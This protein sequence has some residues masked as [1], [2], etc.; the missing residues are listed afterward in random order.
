[1]SISEP[2][3]HSDDPT[4]PRAVIYAFTLAVVVQLIL[5]WRGWLYWDQ[6]LLYNLGTDFATGG[7]LQPFGK[8]TSGDG[9]VPGSLLQL[10]V[11]VPLSLWMNTRASSLA[12]VL[13]QLAVLPLVY[14]ATRSLFQRKDVATWTAVLFALSPWRLYHG[15]FI[16]E[17]NY[18]LILGPIHYW[19]CVRLY[20]RADVRPWWPS[21]IL[22]WT[23]VAAP[24]LHLSGVIL[25]LA[26]AILFAAR[27]FRPHWPAL[28]AGLALGTATLI[29]TLRAIAGG[30]YPF[31]QSSDPLNLI[32]I[33]PL[34]DAYHYWVR[35]ASSDLGRRLRQATDSEFLEIGVG[36][37][38]IFTILL[39]LWA[40]WSVWRRNRL[41]HDRQDDRRACYYCWSLLFGLLIAN[42]VSDLAPQGWYALV[43]AHGSIVLFAL[44]LTRRGATWRRR[45]LILVLGTSLVN[46]AVIGWGH[47][48][49]VRP[50][51]PAELRKVAPANLPRLEPEVAP[52]GG[53]WQR[54]QSEAAEATPKP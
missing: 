27:W 9:A 43:V 33:H 25:G 21:L 46:I 24:Q 5:W 51:D 2:A 42:A 11:G 1:M 3:E 13:G 52:F 39:V 30:T 29:G 28:L 31:P 26:T 45:W 17:P 47:P 18:L 41:D 40:Q 12:M 32:Q 53:Y 20:R 19:A 8:L 38:A 10:V 48:M 16:W 23:V 36:G 34:V 49:Y 14:R 15:G 50:E 37:L 6:A 4:L 22:G 44:W 35:M 54:L 7:G